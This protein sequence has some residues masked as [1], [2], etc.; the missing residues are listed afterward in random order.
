M[1]IDNDAA[2]WIIGALATTIAVT[3]GYIA[4]MHRADRND[5]KETHGEMMT[6]VKQSTEV[7]GALK[8]AVEANTKATD[9]VHRMVGD[10][11]RHER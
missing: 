7:S 8:A 5:R 9:A 3:A 6:L 10:Y 11:I 1:T 2:M 4:A